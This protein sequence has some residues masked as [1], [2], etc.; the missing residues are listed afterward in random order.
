[1]QEAT[2]RTVTILDAK[3]EKAN[4]P[5]VVNENCKH[6]TMFQWNGLLKLLIK[7]EERFDETLGDWKTEL[8]KFQL[9]VPW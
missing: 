2:N 6:L 7:F 5:Q 8:I 1:M 4:L 9:K 3:Y